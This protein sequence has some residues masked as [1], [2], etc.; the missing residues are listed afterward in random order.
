VSSH[1]LTR[2]ETAAA[3]WATAKP[4]VIALAIGLITGPIISS[5]A[6]F[7]VRTSTAQAAMRAGVVEQQGTFCAERARGAATTDAAPL[8]WQARRELAQQWA[9][10][11]GSTVADPDVIYACAEKLSR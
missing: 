1:T 3:K 11:P 2:R 6:G 8:T 5:L 9:I 4:I 10:M 7:Q